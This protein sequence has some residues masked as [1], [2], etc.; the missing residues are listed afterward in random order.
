MTIV[1]DLNYTGYRAS[2]FWVVVKYELE[3]IS[4]KLLWPVL[5]YYICT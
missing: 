3:R 5:R 1:N 2:Y 4:R